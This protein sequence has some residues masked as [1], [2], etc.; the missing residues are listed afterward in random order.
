MSHT[1]K[2]RGHL[3]SLSRGGTSKAIQASVPHPPFRW[4]TRVVL[5]GA[6]LLGIVILLMVSA[7]DALVPALAVTAVPVV[8][9]EGAGRRPGTSVVQASGWI[10]ADPY[11]RHVPALTDGIVR[12]VLVLEGDRVEKGQVVARL[13]PEDALLDLNSARAEADHR[14]ALLVEAK[15]RLA[16]AQT[17]WDNPV[18]HERNVAVTQAH[19]AENRA[20]LVQLQAEIRSAE[21]DLER[22][23]SDHK[24]ISSLG[25]SNVAPEAEV[26]NARTRMQAQE[27]SVEA[28]KHRVE[29]VGAQIRSAEAEL[30]AA[31]SQ[32]DL[33]TSEVEALGV[34]NALVARVEAELIRSRAELAKAELRASR[35]EVRSDCDGIVVQRF[36]EPGGKVMLGTDDKHSA[37]IVSVYD[38]AHLQVRVDV[39]LAEAGKIAAGQAAEVVVEVLPDRVFQGHVSRIAHQADIQRN[40]LQAKVRIEDP[41]ALLRP[42]M[43]ARVR[44][45]AVLEAAPGGATG[46]SLYAPRDAV[47]AGHAWVVSRF[48]GEHGV[49]RRRAVR[50]GGG[51][52]EG[53]VEIADGLQAGDLVV[54]AGTEN[55]KAGSRVRVATPGS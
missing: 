9:R 26:T 50:L 18:E 55:L 39:P 33:R 25:E 2:R 42:E 27:A 11:L 24:R 29:V 49:A 32:R 37:Q 5:P 28:M 22:L 53:W 10:E 36:V 38:P 47:K 23:R 6:V 16:A 48:D 15:A 1:A 44:F 30:K 4:A 43:L 41:D 35:L 51:E 14:E 52:R 7:G 54:T 40:T 12:E 31:V 17:V 8:E 19:I 3:L 34:G 46:T 13:V 21:A 45:L 20:L